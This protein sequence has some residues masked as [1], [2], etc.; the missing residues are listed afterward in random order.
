MKLLVVQCSSAPI[1]LPLLLLTHPVLRSSVNV[2]GKLHTSR[3]KRVKLT[4]LL[5][6]LR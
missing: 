3:K 2:R 5:N 1:L 4:V 6:L